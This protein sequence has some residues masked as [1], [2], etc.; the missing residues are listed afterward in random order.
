MTLDERLRDREQGVLDR[1]T[2]AGFRDAY[3][4][5]A[6]RREYLGKFWYRPAGGESWAD[7]AL[8][9]RAVLLELRLTMSDERVLL[10]THDVVILV[11]RYIL[12]G[13]SPTEAT[14]WSGQLRNC[15]LT[16]YRR[17]PDGQSLLLDRFNDAT[18]LDGL[19]IP[20]T[21]NG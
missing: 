9:L 10:V 7:V 13:L 11:A 6:A 8:R 17:A 15:S 14:Q 2:T 5:E 19:A 16:A 12:E 1:L 21:S 3:P 20:S 18:A 4:D